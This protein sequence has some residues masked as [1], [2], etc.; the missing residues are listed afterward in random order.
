M[1]TCGLSLGKGTACDAHDDSDP[2]LGRFSFTPCPHSHSCGFVCTTTPASND[3]DRQTHENPQHED[4]TEN[5]HENENENE[6]D[7]TH[8]NPGAQNEKHTAYRAH[9]VYPSPPPTADEPKRSVPLPGAQQHQQHQRQEEGSYAYGGIL[10]SPVVLMRAACAP[11]LTLP[12]PLPAPMRGPGPLSPPPTLPTPTHAL[13]P[14]DP[15]LQ[16]IAEHEGEAPEYESGEWYEEQQLLSPISPEWTTHRAAA[17]EA[18]GLMA[19]GDGDGDGESEACVLMAQPRYPPPRAEAEGDDVLGAAGAGPALRRLRGF[20]GDR[21]AA[22]VHLGFPG[23]MGHRALG[24]T[25]ALALYHT[26]EQQDSPALLAQQI[27]MD[28]DENEE[29]MYAGAQQILDAPPAC[30]RA[31]PCDFDLDSYSYADSDSDSL[32]SDHTHD[33]DAMQASP[34]LGFPGAQMLDEEDPSCASHVFEIEPTVLFDHDRDAPLLGFPGVPGVQMQDS[35]VLLGFLGAQML[36][37]DR[38]EDEDEDSERGFA[39]HAPSPFLGFPGVQMLDEEDEGLSPPFDHAK[40]PS[41]FEHDRAILRD[42]DRASSPFSSPESLPDFYSDSDSDASSISDLADMDDLDMDMDMDLDLASPHASPLRAFASLPSPD[43][44]DLDL[45]ADLGF[46]GPAA[47]PSPSRRAAAPLPAFDAEPFFP[48]CG[49]FAPDAANLPTDP[50]LTPSNALL[51]DLP[52]P[53]AAPG[54]PS[55][56]AALSPAQLAARLPPGYPPAELHALLAVRHRA[57]AALARALADASPPAPGVA[58]GLE[59]ELR[60]NVPR[61]AGEPRRRRKRAK[62]MGREVDALVGLVVGLSTSTSSSS[63]STSSST[64][65][66]AAD[67]ERRQRKR[68]GEKA[69]LG[70][71][72]L[73]SVP[74]LVARMILRRRERCVRGLG[75]GRARVGGPSP[76]RHV[77]LD[78]EEGGEP[79]PMEVDG[80]PAL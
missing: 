10:D 7:N 27:P 59:Y 62:E 69:G 20:P 33:H 36:H 37:E 57:A 11:G 18:C 70:L 68:R 25:D 66:A 46:A 45:G 56:L 16:P 29:E 42:F 14:G 13:P 34:V 60:K 72:G 61:D 54:A 6:N 58:G 71:A 55:P 9:T 79:P 78:G 39:P 24:G 44:D 64:S 52:A 50:D 76:L 63:T 26:H 74:A 43:L 12:M 75:E 3:H 5:P 22:A 19:D 30:D 80:G 35:P 2:D 47:S 23:V 15:P 53:P 67:E 32:D 38:D 28:E 31:T 73:A 77:V 4:E 51:L 1:V 65:S 40:A 17:G 48:A 21:G 8:E 41:L 49:V